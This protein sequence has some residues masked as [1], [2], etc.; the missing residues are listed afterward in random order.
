VLLIGTHHIV[1]CE[2]GP[3]ATE[4][5]LEVFLPQLYFA[6]IRVA[7]RNAIYCTMRS[8]SHSHGNSARSVSTAIV[9]HKSRDIFRNPRINKA[10]LTDRCL[11]ACYLFVFPLHCLIAVVCIRADFVNDRSY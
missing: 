1:Q 5:Q 3:T 8:W 10:A 2:V 4:I 6:D 9:L 11:L 7:D